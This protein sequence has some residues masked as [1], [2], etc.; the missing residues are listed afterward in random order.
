VSAD[1]PQGSELQQL[2]ADAAELRRQYRAASQEEP[3]IHLDQAIRAAARRVAGARPGGARMAASWRV[4]A[5][6]AAVV[7]VSVTLAVMV[8]RREPQLPTAKEQPPP[9]AARS[10]GA[11]RDQAEAPSESDAVKEKV[12]PSPSKQAIQ[13]R[14][15]AEQSP[16]LPATPTADAVE[17][18]ERATA[19]EAQNAAAPAATGLRVE[20]SPAA[21]PLK[22]SAAAPPVGAAG[23]NAPPAQ[24]NLQEG[25][26]KPAAGET[27]A[28]RPLAKK[29]AQAEPAETDSR[30]LPWD[31]DPQAWLAHIEA[32]RMMGRTAEAA[33]SF[34]TFRTRY[35]DYRLPDGY[36]APAP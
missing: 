20:L 22:P 4:P 36:V 33:A 31:N 5:A 17:K 28:A 34:R 7:V 27:A 18:D 16:P 6:I 21:A 10:A 12:G 1:K 24:S 11:E 13:T 35:P 3:P 30:G 8:G 29:R 14:S 23:A 25:A 32:L 9:A 15:K 19:S 2:L 26:A